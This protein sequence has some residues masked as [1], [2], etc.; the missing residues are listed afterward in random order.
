MPGKSLIYVS[1]LLSITLFSSAVQA[2]EK[3]PA[4]DVKRC[5]FYTLF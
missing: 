2:V 1:F 4:T 3:E 5:E